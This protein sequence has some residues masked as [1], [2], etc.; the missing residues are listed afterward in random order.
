[1]NSKLL[2]SCP[3]LCDPVDCSTLH[4]LLCPWGFS[5]QEH[6]SVQ[7]CPPPGI[8][9][10][11]GLNSRF[12]CVSHWQA[13]SLTLAPPGKPTTGDVL[14]CAQLLSHVQLFATPWTIVCQ[15]P[16]S[17]GILLARTLKW[18]AMPSSRGSSQS[19]DQTQVSHASGRFFTT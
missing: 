15:T 4:R 13:D 1:M 14:C 12:L 11:Q 3:T 2:K 17:M 10:T 8:F 6:L 7:S 19:R 9:L 16:L 5:R 18:V